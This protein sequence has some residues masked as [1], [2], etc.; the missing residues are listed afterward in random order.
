MTQGVAHHVKHLP[1]PVVIFTLAIIACDPEFA[2]S[3]NHRGYQDPELQ[4]YFYEPIPG[5]GGCEGC[6]SCFA[7]TSDSLGRLCIR[8]GSSYIGADLQ[9]AE[10]DV[11]L[12]KFLQNVDWELQNDET[13]FCPG[14]G[15]CTLQESETPSGTKGHTEFEVILSP[16][17]KDMLPSQLRFAVKMALDPL[18]SSLGPTVEFAGALTPHPP[19][20]WQWALDPQ[21]DPIPNKI[22][23]TM[24]HITFPAPAIAGFA[25]CSGFVVSDRHVLTAAHCFLERPEND[26]FGDPVLIAKPEDLDVRIGGVGSPGDPSAADDLRFGAVRI[27]PHCDLNLDLAIVELDGVTGAKPLPR[28]PVCKGCKKAMNFRGYGY[29]VSASSAGQSYDWGG[30]KQFALASLSQADVDDLPPGFPDL[31][32]IQVMKSGENSGACRGDSGGLVVAQSGADYI[33]TAVIIARA[34]YNQDDKI[35]AIEAIGGRAFAF[36]QYNS[37]GI[38]REVLRYL[39]IRL[40]QGVVSSWVDAVVAGGVQCVYDQP[41]PADK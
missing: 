19:P 6:V 10:D 39:T 29:G 20:A 21:V 16:L 32:Q 7:W 27:Y 26:P 17:Y 24:A 25:S 31:S 40:D 11:L 9:S 2:S 23:S 1:S 30:L 5:G 14:E 18:D 22:A 34:G 28:A 15:F 8:N 13:S 12:E 35:T 38:E 36:S 37:C 4:D 33:A 3:Q 41:P